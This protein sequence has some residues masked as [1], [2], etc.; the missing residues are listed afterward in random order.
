MID[1]GSPGDLERDDFSSNHHLASVIG[2]SMIFS[3]NRCP[4]LGIML[5]EK[6]IPT[7]NLR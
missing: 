4:L 7:L 1:L 6:E 2:L 5:L 3:K